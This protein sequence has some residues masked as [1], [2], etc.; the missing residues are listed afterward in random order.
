MFLLY[1]R[2]LA[3]ARKPYLIRLLFT[4]KNG[5]FGAISVTKKNCACTAPISKLESHM[6]DRVPY[7][8]LV[9]CE[10]VFGP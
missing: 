10:Q 1:R 9:H 5:D 6:A 7:H 4:H 2:A 8:T 3:P